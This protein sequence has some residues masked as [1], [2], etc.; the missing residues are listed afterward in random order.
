M[1]L[2]VNNSTACNNA[3]HTHIEILIAFLYVIIFSNFRR[4][5]RTNEAA[6]ANYSAWYENKG[7]LHARAT[8]LATRK[9][10]FHLP[11]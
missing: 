9:I 8:F 2:F 10:A 11:A 5:Y 4:G 6:T 7:A 3:L 1:Y